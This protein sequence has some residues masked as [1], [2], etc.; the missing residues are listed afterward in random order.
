MAGFETEL[1]RT[2]ELDN[3]ILIAAFSGWNDA[4]G[5]ATWAIR[6]LSENTQASKFA[7]LNAESFYD[8]ST[9]RPSV[10]LN[11]DSRHIVWPENNF[12][13]SESHSLLFVH[14]TEPQL[15]WQTFTHEIMGIARKLNVSM[16]ITL[17]ALLA[18][19]PHSRP[20]LIHGVSDNESINQKFDLRRS[21]YEGPTGIVGVL[22]QAAID[23]EIPNLSLW[24]TVPNYV[25]GAESPKAA[26]ALID[27]IKE[28]IPVSVE[29]T[30]LEIASAAYERQINQII[31]G[32]ED[33]ASYVDSLE[34]S[35]DAGDFDQMDPS[36]FVEEVEQFLREQ[37]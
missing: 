10:R 20:V 29:T 24:A 8:F 30:D 6:H 1:I 35:F 15:K 28:I 32:D 2:P 21:S 19:V 18:E 16:V 25:A 14:G 9:Q 31:E 22:N 27:K 3:P 13:A 12:L 23:A 11:D 26:L 37:E 36:G 7:S 33:T 34:S 4:G 17:G 5:A